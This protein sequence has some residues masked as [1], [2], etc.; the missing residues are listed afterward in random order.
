MDCRIC[1]EQITSKKYICELECSHLMCTIC[2][3][4]LT[5][6]TCPYCRHPIKNKKDGKYNIEYDIEEVIYDLNNENIVEIDNVL[7]MSELYYIEDLFY[8]DSCDIIHFNRKKKEKKSN[9]R[10]KKKKHFTSNKDRDDF[11][12]NKNK[13]NWKKQKN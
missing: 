12:R 11:Q 6:N 1:M 13:K 5:R 4:R 2:F 10:R 9:T 7:P 3:E 8:E